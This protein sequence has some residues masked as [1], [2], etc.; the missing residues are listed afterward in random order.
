MHHYEAVGNRV[1]L[2]RAKTNLGACSI[3]AGQY[4]QAILPVTEAVQFFEAVQHS[5]ML[6][7]N[8]AN[9]A[10]ALVHLGDAAQ[11]SNAPCKLCAPKKKMCARMRLRRW[12]GCAKRRAN[13]ARPS[14]VFVRLSKMRSRLKTAGRRPRPTAPWARYC[15]HRAS[16]M[17]LVLVPQRIKYLHSAEAAK[18]DRA[19]GGVAGASTVDLLQKSLEPAV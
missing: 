8:A 11:P 15:R 5:N 1:Q 7:L 16:G 2:N 4:A 14:T 6:A 18:G 12:V 17:R 13:S 3:Q 10:E 19:D 9:L